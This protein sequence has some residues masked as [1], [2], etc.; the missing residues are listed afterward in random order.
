MAAFLPGDLPEVVAA[1]AEARAI[2][3][4]VGAAPL[5][6]HLDALTLSSAER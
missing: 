6:A 3:A 5:L 4:D 2:L 1:A